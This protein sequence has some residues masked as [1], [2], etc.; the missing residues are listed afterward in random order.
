M[1]AHIALYAKE[2]NVFYDKD[3]EYN[4]SQTARY[5]IGG[6]IE[7][8]RAIAAIANPTINSYKRLIPNFEA[9]CYITWG[10]FN[11]SALIRVPAKKEPDIEI[12]NADTCANP[13]LLYASL[14]YAGLDGIKKKIEYNPIEKNLYTLTK[15]E[16][17]EY[18]I[19]RMPSNLMEAIE[20]LENDDLFRRSIGKEVID[21][22]TEMKKKE[23]RSY[24]TEVTNLEYRFYLSY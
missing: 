24:M 13:Y 14:L 15:R 21:M 10:R 1:H 18:G 19:K 6:I 5:F 8:A 9:P 2:K 23:W 12:R 20:E 3:D 22:Y 17:R 4:L 7:H 11:R 16:I